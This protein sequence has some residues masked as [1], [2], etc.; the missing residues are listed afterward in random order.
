MTSEGAEVAVADDGLMK[1]IKNI[2][3]HQ[4]FCPKCGRKTLRI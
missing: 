3:E 4:S 2:E 1:N